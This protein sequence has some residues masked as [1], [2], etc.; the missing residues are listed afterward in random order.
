MHFVIYLIIFSEWGQLSYPVKCCDKIEKNYKVYIIVSNQ[1]TTDIKLGNEFYRISLELITEA[2]NSNFQAVSSFQTFISLIGRI[3][4]F[5]F[6]FLIVSGQILQFSI[7]I[8]ESRSLYW[9]LF[10]GRDSIKTRKFWP[11]KH[12]T[13][14]PNIQFSVFKYLYHN[15]Q[16]L[17]TVSLSVYCGYFMAELQYRHENIFLTK[18]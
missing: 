8:T 2:K 12:E 16:R 7:L 14:R 10:Y 15:F 6:Q 4:I 13:S 9:W 18:A 3:K 1:N 17:R 11:R 5:F